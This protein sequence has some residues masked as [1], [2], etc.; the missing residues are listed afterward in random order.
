MINSVPLL[1]RILSW[2]I[3]RR[4]GSRNGVS[5]FCTSYQTN[6]SPWHK[7]RMYLLIILRDVRYCCHQLG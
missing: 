7:N 2:E 6:L 1:W 5:P 4:L 3:Y